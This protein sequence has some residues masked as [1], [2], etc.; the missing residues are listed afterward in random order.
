MNEEANKVA[1]E[2]I[3]YSQKLNQ[4]M[5]VKFGCV[6]FSESGSINGAL[7]ITDANTLSE[8]LNCFTGT[9]RTKHYGESMANPPADRNDLERRLN[10]TVE[11]E[12][13][14]EVW[15]CIMPMKTLLSGKEAT[16]SMYFSPTNLTNRVAM[17][18]GL[19]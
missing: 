3:R 11:P 8:Y 5:D 6:G 15:H 17:H 4:N 12:V 2:I 19:F 16:V 7:N 14:V 9:S 1:E 18:L 10:L 13:S